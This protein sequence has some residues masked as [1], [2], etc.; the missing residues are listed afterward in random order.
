M[1]YAMIVF[2]SIVLVATLV[3][4]LATSQMVSIWFSCASVIPIVLAC[5]DAPEWVQICAFVA[6]SVLLLILT[7]PFVKKVKKQP[8]RTNIDMIIGTDAIVTETIHN[9]LSKGRVM[10][11]GVSWKALSRDGS[12][13][14][15]GQTVKIMAI[16]SAKLIVS[17]IN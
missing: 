2:W 11:S 3:V 15:K 9:E 12:V 16:D 6:M 10:V 7:R 5:F 13:I 8:E 14:E 1:D 17:K 4:E